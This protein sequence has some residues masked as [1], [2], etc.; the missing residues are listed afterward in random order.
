L[1]H[2]CR[3]FFVQA[4]EAEDAVQDTFLR[5]CRELL[6]FRGECALK[7][8]LYRIARNSCLNRL[9]GSKQHVSLDEPAHESQAADGPSPE[10]QA[11]ARAIIAAV[12]SRLDQRDRMILVMYYQLEMTSDE[13]ARALPA[14]LRIG[15]DGVRSRVHR[16]IKATIAE[17]H[18][19]FGDN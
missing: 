12:M 17:V 1:L 9:R 15:A 4:D 16:Q 7:T 10:V 8:W 2:F 6:S 11:E 5:A 3:R 18:K 14:E 19:D 13:I